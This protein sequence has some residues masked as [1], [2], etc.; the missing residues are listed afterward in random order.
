MHEDNNN[1][2][3]EN[4][5]TAITWSMPNFHNSRRADPDTR[6]ITRPI[7]KINDLNPSWFHVQFNSNHIS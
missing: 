6:A 7:K 4:K 1:V 3:R 5:K 2:T